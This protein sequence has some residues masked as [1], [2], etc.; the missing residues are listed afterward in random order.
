MI[1]TQDELAADKPR[2]IPVLVTP[3]CVTRRETT[4]K[5]VSTLASGSVKKKKAGLLGVHCPALTN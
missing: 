3:Q 4:P 2:D 5:E 1:A